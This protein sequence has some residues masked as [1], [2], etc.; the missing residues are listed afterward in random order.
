MDGHFKSWANTLAG[1]LEAGIAFKDRNV[2]MVKKKKMVAG[3]LEE[4]GR[5]VFRE[6]GTEKIH[7]LNA[8]FEMPLS[9]PRRTIRKWLKKPGGWG[10]GQS[11]R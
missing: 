9:Y 2:D 8:N 11:R 3:P 6:G 1:K 10:R 7:F 4:R 5:D